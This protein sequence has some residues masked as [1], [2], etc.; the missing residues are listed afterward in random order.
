VGG[1]FIVLE[2]PDG[3]GKTTQA[4]LLSTWMRDRD[5]AH[6]VAREPGGTPVGEAIRKVVLGSS[7]LDISPETE[8]LMLLAA[9]AAFV[10]DLVRPALARGQ[11]VLA[12]RFALS[13]LAY[14][15]Y[16]RGVS[17]DDIRDGIRIATG[18]LAPDLYVVLDLPL[19]EGV[20]RQSAEGHTP[21]RIEKEGDRF[22]RSVREGY[23][24]LVDSEPDVCLLDGSG[25]PGDVH[26]R[27]CTVLMERFPETFGDPAV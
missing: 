21:D 10:R 25:S 1:R 15:G 2:G 7:E 16:G 18:G 19:G 8:L 5:I 6:V 14:Q 26:G 3:V 11:V 12:D 9:R 22:R 20:A 17:L 23:L 4:E 27:I 13:T 24:A